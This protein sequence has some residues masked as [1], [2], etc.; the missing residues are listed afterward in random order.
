M[1]TNYYRIPTDSEMK[2]KKEKL[3][4]LVK[5]LDLSPSSIESKFRME[6]ADS[7]DRISI[8]DEFIDGTRIH[9]GKRSSGWKFLW[10]FNDDKY[11]KNKEE[12]LKFIRSGRIVNEYGEEIEVEEFI[13]MALNWNGLDIIE[14]YKQYPSRKAYSFGTIEKYVDGL[15][16]S[17]TADFS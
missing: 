5:N 9:L 16:V 8:W 1:G 7:F 15:R 2:L 11:Y 6:Q 14:Y 17:N 12:L 4:N 3:T 10:N 13:E